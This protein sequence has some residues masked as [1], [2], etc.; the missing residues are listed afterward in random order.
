MTCSTG[1]QVFYLAERGYD[2]VSS[3]FSPALLAIARNKAKELNRNI[4]FIDGDMR[5]SR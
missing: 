3:D 1:S 5:E 4:I 2:V